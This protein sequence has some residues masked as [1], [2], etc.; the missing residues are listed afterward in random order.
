MELIVT[1]CT[2]VAEDHFKHSPLMVLCALSLAC[3]AA[4]FALSA[5]SLPVDLALSATLPAVGFTCFL[6]SFAVS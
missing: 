6:A 2:S 4:F 1:V 5:A 3:P